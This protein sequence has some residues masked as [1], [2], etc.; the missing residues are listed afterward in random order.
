[1]TDPVKGAVVISGAGRDKGEYLAVVDAHADRVC[2]CNGR[3]RPLNRPK[4]KNPVHLIET[5]KTLPADA[6]RGNK[7]LK[8]ALAGIRAEQEDETAGHSSG[9]S[10]R[11]GR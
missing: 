4:S 5:G 9:Q 2:V 1:M 11:Q 7:A 6:F 10:E 3:D 8:K